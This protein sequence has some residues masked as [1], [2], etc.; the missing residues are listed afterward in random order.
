MMR[1]P[2]QRGA[3]DHVAFADVG[4]PAANFI[5]R[6]PETIALEPWYHHPHDSFENVSRERI[7]TAMRVVV[8]AAT[9]VVCRGRPRAPS[10]RGRGRGG[11]GGR[12]QHIAARDSD[13]FGLAAHVYADQRM[14]IGRMRAML[15]ASP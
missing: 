3:S 8:G 2:F 12:R 5:W 4:I 9:Q 6:E 7:E 14:E 11:P 15:Q 10:E 1:A 13:I